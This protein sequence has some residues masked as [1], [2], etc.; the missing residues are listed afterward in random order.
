M[1]TTWY[2]KYIGFVNDMFEKLESN[3]AKK[4]EA[5]VLP[6]RSILIN[7][8]EPE[9]FRNFNSSVNQ[10]STVESQYPNFET[11]VEKLTQLNGFLEEEKAVYAHWSNEAIETI[12]VSVF[13]L[14]ADGKYIDELTLMEEF[15]RQALIFT[16]LYDSCTEHEVGN[17][18]HNARVLIHFT[19]CL[20]T[21]INSFL[22]LQTP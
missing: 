8:I 15:K 16:A 12:P 14:S 11:W 2:E 19:R 20:D 21:T 18:A 22:S 7:R 10:L 3:L 5:E 1:L 4:L 13:F 9:M 6:S 17:M